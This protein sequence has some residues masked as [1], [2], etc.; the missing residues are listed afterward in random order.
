MEAIPFVRRHHDTAVVVFD[1]ESGVRNERFD[2]VLKD[3]LTLKS[4]LIESIKPVLPNLM[5]KKN[6]QPR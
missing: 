4:P 1:Y 3:M 2:T 5:I 6:N